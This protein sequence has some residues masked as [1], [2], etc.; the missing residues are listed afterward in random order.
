[1]PERAAPRWWLPTWRTGAGLCLTFQTLPLPDL[2]QAAF[3]VLQGV[4]EDA[5]GS[6]GGSH[7]LDA[8]VRDV[9]V[10]RPPRHGSVSHAFMIET[11]ARW[12]P[13]DFD[14]IVCV[15]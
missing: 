2:T 13:P 9:V 8:A 15:S 10:K 4:D 12:P 5:K 3:G 11:T 14:P 1:M 6:V 7:V